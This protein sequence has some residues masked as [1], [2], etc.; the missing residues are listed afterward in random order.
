MMANKAVFKAHH[1]RHD[2]LKMGTPASPLRPD[3]PPHPRPANPA[4]P[5]PLLSTKCRKETSGNQVG[6]GIASGSDMRAD[7]VRKGSRQEG[8]G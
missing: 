8:E 3:P 6:S 4:N 1:L 5:N 2:K 7:W